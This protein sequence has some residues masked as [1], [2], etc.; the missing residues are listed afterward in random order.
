MH[1]ANHLPGAVGLLGDAAHG[2]RDFDIGVDHRA[3]VRVAPIGSTFEQIERAARIAGNRRERLRKFVA[4]QRG[5]LAD[6]RESGAG[7]QPLLAGARQFFDA[8]LLADIDEGAHPAGL[9]ALCVEQR[10]LEDQHRKARAVLAH[11]DRFEAFAR[12]HAAGQT[13]RL[14]LLIFVRQFGRPIGRLGHAGGVAM[15]RLRSSRLP[16]HGHQFFCA[17][18]DHLAEGRV[19]ISEPATEVARAQAGD[20]RVFHRLAERERLGKFELRLEAPPRVAC[21][22][23]QHRHQRDRDGSHQRG[24]QV[25]EDIGRSAPAVDAQHERDARQVDQLLRS[26][27]ARAGATAHADDGETRAIGLGK[28]DLLAAC[29]RRAEQLGQHVAQAIGRN[30]ITALDRHAQL[31]QFDATAFGHRHVVARRIGRCHQLAGS[32]AGQCDIV[33]LAAA[34]DLVEDAH[35]VRGF[36]HG[37]RHQTR[38]APLQPDHLAVLA[39][40][41]C[42][43]GW[44]RCIAWRVL[45]GQPQRTQA[46]NVALQAGAQISYCVGGVAIERGLGLLDLMA[47]RQPDHGAQQCKHEHG[48]QQPQIPAL[49]GVALEA[50]DAHRTLML[51][52]ARHACAPD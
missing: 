1:A 11:E 52:A 42:C 2:H 4:Q 19:D 41:R 23:H 15:T 43:L 46:L 20:H 34:C 26:E 38:I 8:T 37:Q 5:H 33:L 49:P 13:M 28:G 51:R 7:L 24:Q 39:Q 17:E 10:R 18:A 32:R 50:R 25:G 3:T 47:P 21:Q 30:Q 22:Q 31:H 44:P 40:Q 9:H 29:K 48:E 14:S 6:G 35:A 27:D 12:W 16:V 45:R 36:E